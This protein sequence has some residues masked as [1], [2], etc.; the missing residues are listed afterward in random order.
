MIKASA[1][2]DLCSVFSCQSVAI[3]EATSKVK[4]TTL[5]YT[6]QNQGQYSIPARNESMVHSIV[7]AL[8]VIQINCNF[9]H[10]VPN[11]STSIRLLND[12]IFYTSI[13][14]IT[15]NILQFITLRQSPNAK[16]PCS[17]CILYRIF[18]A[19]L[20]AKAYIGQVIDVHAY[21]YLIT[22]ICWVA[23][24]RLL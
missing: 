11:Q 13:R 9:Q 16:D 22:E 6:S 15:V 14:H 18:Y 21:T 19:D 2:K 17:S 10:I 5:E 1:K 3:V 24:P 23:I 12:G 4:I 7:N 20:P 8:I